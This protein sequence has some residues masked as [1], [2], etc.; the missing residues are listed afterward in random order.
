MEYCKSDRTAQTRNGARILVVVSVV[1][2]IMSNGCTPKRVSRADRARVSGTVT[3]NGQ[4]VKGGEIAFISVANGG[5]TGACT[6]RENGKYYM[7]DAPL[8]ENKVTVDT[9]SIKPY[10]G[11]RYVQIPAK[12]SS[13]ETT[14][15]TFDVKKGESTYD[16]PLK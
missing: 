10:L 9:E 5:K 16:I 8:G 14:D 6:I 1:G 4:V 12:Y 15:L 7:S 3:Y 13:A 2:L 11:A